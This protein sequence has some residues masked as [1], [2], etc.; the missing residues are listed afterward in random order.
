MDEQKSESQNSE[1][2]KDPLLS[3][4]RHSGL[5]Y[6]Q[7][8]VYIAKTTGGFETAQY[9]DT[10]AAEVRRQNEKAAGQGQKELE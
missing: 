5:T 8:K 4:A 9:S 2:N 1:I 7:A 6:N 3:L 10:D